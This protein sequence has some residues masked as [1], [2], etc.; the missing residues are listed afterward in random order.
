MYLLEN[1]LWDIKCF[2]PSAGGQ[3]PKEASGYHHNKI[4]VLVD[5]FPANDPY[6]GL[7]PD[8]Q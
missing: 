5:L 7:S 4:S 8:R 3:V 6:S 2:H 1:I